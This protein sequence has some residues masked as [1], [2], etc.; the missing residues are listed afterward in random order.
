MTKE[1]FAEELVR[2]FPEYREVYEDHLNAYGEVLG[3]VFFCELNPI[4]SSLLRENQDR[5][6]IR[7]YIDF[8]EEMYREGDGDVR[9]IVQ[10]TIL[11]YLGDDETVLRNAF[12]Y[13]S[14]ELMLASQAVEA[15]WGR[16]EIRIYH[17]HGKARYEWRP[18]S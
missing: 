7:R 3:H 8:L 17:R 9:N 2:R 4:L 16:R 1:H 12:E 11:E 6:R 18:P 13:F 14:E 15:G 10:V 5:A